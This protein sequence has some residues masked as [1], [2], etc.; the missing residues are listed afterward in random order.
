MVVYVIGYKI[1]KSKAPAASLPAAPP[2]SSFTLIPGQVSATVKPGTVMT[3]NLPPNSFW[4]A[5]P[6]GSASGAGFVPGAN[7]SGVTAP[8]SG[9]TAAQAT[10]GGNGATA[11]AFWTDSTGTPQ[12]TTMTFTG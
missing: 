3:F 11:Q 9:A 4:S 8:S 1:G 12:S 2:T 5:G 6:S 10:Y 7:L